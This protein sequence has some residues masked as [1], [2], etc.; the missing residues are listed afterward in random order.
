[1]PNEPGFICSPWPNLQNLMHSTQY[2]SCD[3]YLAE[4]PSQ[5]YCLYCLRIFGSVNNKQGKGRCCSFAPKRVDIRALDERRLPSST[6][7]KQQQT[8]AGEIS[9]H[10]VCRN[11]LAT[12]IWRSTLG[13]T[14]LDTGGHNRCN[15]HNFLNLP[16]NYLQLRT[17]TTTQIV[18][19]H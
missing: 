14:D 4:D 12:L 19:E 6:N 16:I 17:S 2:V 18:G 1:M 5:T 8:R 7:A 13:F 3:L 10:E 15:L 9:S 11:L